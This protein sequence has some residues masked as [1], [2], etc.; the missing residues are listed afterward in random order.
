MT[1]CTCEINAIGSTLFCQILPLTIRSPNISDDASVSSICAAQLSTVFV[2][3]LFH[4][5]LTGNKNSPFYVRYKLDHFVALSFISSGSSM[6]FCS[7]SN[8]VSQHSTCVNFMKKVAIS[9]GHSNVEVT[10]VKR[11]NCCQYYL[12]D[13]HRF[14]S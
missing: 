6:V 10:G 3:K 14:K 1:T 2:P 4:L 12:F 9:S 5:G 8:R 11:Q 13:N 7:S